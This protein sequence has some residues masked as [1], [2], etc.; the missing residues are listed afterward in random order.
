MGETPILRWWLLAL[1][2]GALL[3][4]AAAALLPTHGGSGDRPDARST[5]Y[6]LAA[7]QGDVLNRGKGVSDSPGYIVGRATVVD[8]D[9]IKIRDQSIRLF[10]IDALE[11]DQHCLA[12]GRRQRCAQ[13]AALALADKIG[14]RNVICEKI[15]RDRYGRIV[16][17]CRAGGDNLN[18]WLVA[19]GWALA[20]RRYSRL[21]VEAEETAKRAERGVWRTRFVPPWAAR[22]GV[23]L[24]ARREARA[25]AIKGNIGA[26][27][28][29]IYHVPGGYYYAD[30]QIDES[31]GERWFCSQAEARSAGWRAAYR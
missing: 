18:A 24:D 17:V 14:A 7:R 30:T 10:A 15:D 23:K 25:C 21:Y 4:A 9:T 28:E 27:G 6:R 22:R 2:G 16:G 19:E 12:G 8:G 13:R 26:N 5:T 1:I 29:R 11:D 20:Y 3:G 31:K